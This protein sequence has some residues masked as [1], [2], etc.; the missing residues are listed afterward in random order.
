MP[1]GQIFG[2]GL[3]FTQLPLL[4]VS[5]CLTVAI[6]SAKKINNNNCISVVIYVL[7]D[8]END[9]YLSTFQLVIPEEDVGLEQYD[10][11]LEGISFTQFKMESLLEAIELELEEEESDDDDDGD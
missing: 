9:E 1:S 10:A 2:G 8:E 6:R 5:G 4:F 7:H 3:L 11:L